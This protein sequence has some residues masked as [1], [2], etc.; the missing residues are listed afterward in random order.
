MKSHP[1]N[2]KKTVLVLLLLSLSSVAKDHEKGEVSVNG[3]IQE[4][5]C[6]IHLDDIFQS[7]T[8]DNVKVSHI[9]NDDEDKAKDFTIRLINC[10]VD[11]STDTLW[12][13]VHISFDG[14]PDR[15]NGNLFLMS[16]EGSGVAVQIKDTNGQ[17]ISP[18]NRVN[19]AKVE[20]GQT[21]LYFK[22]KLVSNGTQLLLGNL[23]TTIKFT[24]E[25]Q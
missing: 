14:I 25:Y 3:Q 9:V 16:G 4:S 11:R 21:G 12:D 22:I 15:Q 13:S 5:A 10:S 24:I 8:F 2:M 7:L 17:Q 19:I 20:N 6:N 1:V 18:G 23:S